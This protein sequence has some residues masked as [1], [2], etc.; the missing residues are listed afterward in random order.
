LSSLKFCRSC[1]EEIPEDQQ[2]KSFN[3]HIYKAYTSKDFDGTIRRVTGTSDENKLLERFGLIRHEDFKK[4][5]PKS[6]QQLNMEELAAEK[7]K[8]P[9]G[10]SMGHVDENSFKEKLTQGKIA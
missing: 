4:M 2:K 3:I 1:Y 7:G 8:K 9:E 10:I 5:H 6:R